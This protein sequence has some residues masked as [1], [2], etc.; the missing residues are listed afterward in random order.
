MSTAFRM[1]IGLSVCVA[2]FVLLARAVKVEA[3]GAPAQT[4]AP[5][6]FKP[7]SEI[8]HLMEGQELHFN[9]LGELMKDT[10]ARGRIGRIAMHADVLAELANV[11]T[12]N[13]DKSDYRAWA[14]QVRDLARQIVAEAGKKASADDAVL[15]GLMVKINDTCKSCHDAYGE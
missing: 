2:I 7:V 15:K 6:A 9:A 4:G 10:S 1:A 13:R 11:N 3:Q 14:G 12:H 8:H 5:A